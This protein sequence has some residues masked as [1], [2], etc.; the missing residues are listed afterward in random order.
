VVLFAFLPTS[1]QLVF[2]IW[3]AVGLAVYFGYSRARSHMRPGA[4]PPAE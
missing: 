2:P 1:A 4:A 3:G